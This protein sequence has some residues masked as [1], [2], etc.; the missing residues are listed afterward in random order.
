MKKKIYGVGVND[1]NYAVRKGSK[2]YWVY[3]IW[4][5]MMRRCYDEKYHKNKPT[6]IN[7]EVCDEWKTYSIFERWTKD[8]S[9]GF[10]EGCH[11]DK[12]IIGG[13]WN[14]VY[15]PETCCFVPRFINSLILNDDEKRKKKNGNT[16]IGVTYYKNR[17]YAR[18]SRYGEV[19]KIG[20]FDNGKEA[21]NAYKQARE[22]YIKEVA[23]KYYEEEKI[24][25]RVYNALLNYKIDIND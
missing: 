7:C 3:Q 21:F 4:H 14:K 6:Y 25:E 17:Y 20:S 13:K 18:I 5:D 10:T 19:V 8:P 9:N 23:Q 2:V 16:P 22:A 15:S 24:T 11:L 12:D 1:A